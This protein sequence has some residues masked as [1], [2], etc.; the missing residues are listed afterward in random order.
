MAMNHT[1]RECDQV[2]IAGRSPARQASG[3]GAISTR[4]V[5]S[6]LIVDFFWEH[7]ASAPGGASHGCAD[8]KASAELS[9]LH[10]PIL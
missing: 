10:H 5:R 8:R 4:A 3:S 1:L 6:N 7:V 9:S 2:V